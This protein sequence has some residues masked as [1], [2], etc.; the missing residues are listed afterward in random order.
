MHY[1][2]VLKAAR[3]R[4]IDR[5][6]SVKNDFLQRFRVYV[7]FI[8]GI[9]GGWMWWMVIQCGRR[10]KLNT[11]CSSRFDRFDAITCRNISLSQRSARNGFSVTGT[12]ISIEFW[13]NRTRVTR[14][15]WRC[16]FFTYVVNHIII[17]ALFNIVVIIVAIIIFLFLFGQSIQRS[18][19]RLQSRWH[20]KVA[21]WLIRFINCLVN[22]RLFH[23]S[24][25]IRMIFS[26]DIHTW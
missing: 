2:F 16:R 24:M 8:R 3:V 4:I 21:R 9:M 20:I 10:H 7:Q 13:I 15:R 14:I 22:F 25:V 5:E 12:Q 6:C 11:L 17:A 26:T 23:T 18:D 1:N 19:M